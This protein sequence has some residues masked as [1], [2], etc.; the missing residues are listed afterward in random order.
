MVAK[1]ERKTPARKTARPRKTR[2]VARPMPTKTAQVGRYITLGSLVAAGM[3][4]VIGIGTVA[5]LLSEP[6]RRSGKW[7]GWNF[8][9]LSNSARDRLRSRIPTDWTRTVREDLL[10]EAREFVARQTRRFS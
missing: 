10:P 7:G 6:T 9:D 1:L 2:A 5:L 8:N 3:L 4:V